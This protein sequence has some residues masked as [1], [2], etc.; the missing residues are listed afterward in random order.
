MQ[1]KHTFTTEINGM[2]LTISYE[3][4]QGKQPYDSDKFY[5]IEFELPNNPL[6]NRN[7]T[8]KN[9]KAL[10]ETDVIFKAVQKHFINNVWI[11]KP[12]NANELFS[13]NNVDLKKL[14]N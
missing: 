9:I 8:A 4:N 1:T 11:V 13:R 12:V 14:I 2:N 6:D 10:I 5:N 3:V 7:Q